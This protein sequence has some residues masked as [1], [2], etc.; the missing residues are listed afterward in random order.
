MKID[1]VMSNLKMYENKIKMTLA[2]Q[3]KSCTYVGSGVWK[4]SVMQD[5]TGC[6]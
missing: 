1:V 5:M 3:L 4:Q 6:F 2:R